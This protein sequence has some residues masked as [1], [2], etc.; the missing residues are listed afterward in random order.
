M[1]R[2]SFIAGLLCMCTASLAAAQSDDVEFLL[3]VGMLKRLRFHPAVSK[4]S[5]LISCGGAG[6]GGGAVAA[7]VGAI[8]CAA[9]ID[10][11]EELQLASGTVHSADQRRCHNPVYGERRHRSRS[12]LS[13]RSGENY[14]KRNAPPEGSGGAWWGTQI[15]RAYSGPANR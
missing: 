1:D 6:G 7:V 10:A 3:P 15:G 2:R 13:S 11:L 9:G 12:P 14:G 4:A 8:G 5:K